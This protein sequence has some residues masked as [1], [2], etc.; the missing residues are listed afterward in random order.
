MFE[1]RADVVRD[2]VNGVRSHAGGILVGVA[3]NE[4]EE[5]RATSMVLVFDAVWF[6]IWNQI[7]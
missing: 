2:V 1:L 7:N 6:C 5:R 4:R 3:I